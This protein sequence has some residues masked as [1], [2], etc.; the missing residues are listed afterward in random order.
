MSEDSEKVLCDP[1]KFTTVGLPRDDY[2]GAEVRADPGVSSVVE[3]GRLSVSDHGEDSAGL[4]G[5]CYLS[6]LKCITL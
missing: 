1:P 5:L 3:T 4:L 6:H 2:P